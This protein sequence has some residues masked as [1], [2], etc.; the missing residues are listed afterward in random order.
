MSNVRSRG[1]TRKNGT[2]K[3]EKGNTH[4][5]IAE[6]NKKKFINDYETMNRGGPVWLSWLSTQLRLRS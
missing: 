6:R 2:N 3:K 5:N 1:E 4:T